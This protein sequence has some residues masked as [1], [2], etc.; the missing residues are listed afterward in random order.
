MVATAVPAQQIPTLIPRNDEVVYAFRRKIQSNKEFEL[1]NT[2]N[3]STDSSNYSYRFLLTEDGGIIYTHYDNKREFSQS[4]NSGAHL[5]D[6]YKD[7]HRLNYHV[8]SADKSNLSNG[9]AFCIANDQTVPDDVRVILNQA[10]EVLGQ[11]V[12]DQPDLVKEYPAIAERFTAIA[13]R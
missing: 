13:S 8:L 7:G 9:I 10:A 12:K 5:G 6:Y 3:G 1:G 11:L 2:T 4:I